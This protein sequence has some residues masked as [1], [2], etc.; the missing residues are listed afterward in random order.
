MAKEEAKQ[1]G[2]SKK[3]VSPKGTPSKASKSQSPAKGA[4]KNSA[5]KNKK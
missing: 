3:S 4:G 1:R 5:A 2:R